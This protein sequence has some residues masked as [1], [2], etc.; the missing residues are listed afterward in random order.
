MAENKRDYYEVLGVSKGA[1]EEEIKKA[2]KKLARKYHP[3]MNPG[4]KEAEEKFK[5]INEANEVLSDPDKKARYDQFGFAGVDPNYGAGA[6]GGAYGAGGFDFGDLGDIFGSSFGCEKE[7]SIDRIEQ[8]PDCRGS[9][10]A[11]GTTAEVCPDCRGSGVIQQRRQTPLGYMSTS[12]PC[13]RCGGKGKI[14]HQPCPKCG[15]KGMIRHRKTI[16]V[17]IPAGIDNGQ[18]ISLRAQGNAGKNGGPAGD[19]LIVVSVRPHEI[20]R[21]EGT[22][23]L[24]EAPI[25][26][27]QAV[28]GAELEIPTIDG[29]VKY[30]I[31]EGTQSGTTFRLKGKGIPGLNGRGRGEKN[32]E[33]HKGF[34]GK[35]KL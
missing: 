5:E 34:F 4:D 31:P 14:I 24:C 22:S 2:Y 33:E 21:R 32:Y 18:T 13:Q 11:K 12:A 30:T 25:T 10:C 19:L 29:K 6:G 17:S 27:T 15:G 1:S 23:V 28:L 26:F 3:D 7:V 8:C 20:F 9:G 16:K 35:F